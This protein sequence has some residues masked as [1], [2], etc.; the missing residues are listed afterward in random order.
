MWVYSVQKAIYGDK[1]VTSV[2]RYADLQAGRLSIGKIFSR[3]FEESKTLLIQWKLDCP[4]RDQ[5]NFVI[6]ARYGNQFLKER[7]FIGQ[8]QNRSD[9]IV[10][11]NCAPKYFFKN[12]ITNHPWEDSRFSLKFVQNK[13]ISHIVFISRMIFT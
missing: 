3:E 4:R 2:L 11:P 12:P 8:Y 6:S 10:H 9:F 7:T 5:T 1:D 13:S